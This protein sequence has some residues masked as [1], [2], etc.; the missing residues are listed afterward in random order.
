MKPLPAERNP[1]KKSVIPSG[2]CKCTVVVCC[3]SI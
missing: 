1:R 2:L 3:F